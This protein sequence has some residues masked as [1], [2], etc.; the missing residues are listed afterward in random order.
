LAYDEHPNLFVVGDERQAIYRFQ[1]ADSTHFAEFTKQYPRTVTIELTDSFRSLQAILDLSQ[2]LADRQG[3]YQPLKAHREGVAD[4]KL[5]AA[6]DPLAERDQ[7]AGLVEEAIKKG[8]A[9]EEIAVIANK[10]ATADVF[11]E[12]L[13]ARGIPVLRAGDV[14]LSSR[15]VLRALL[16]FMRAVANPLDTASLRESLLAPWW[17]IPL[18]E[19]AEL[20]ARTRD[21][22]LLNTLAET[23]EEIV[24]NIRELQEA[25]LA[26]APLELF[27]LLLSKSGARAFMLSSAD[28]VDDLA[29]LRRLYAHLE[30][31]V[32]RDP[33]RSFSD[34]IE[35]LTKAQEHGLESVKSSVTQR[36]GFVTVITAHKAKGMEFEK[37]FVVGLTAREWEKG[38]RSPVIPSPVDSSKSLDDVIRLFF[39]AM[40]RAKNELVLSYAKETV[41]GKETPPSTLMPEDI[42]CIESSSNPLPEMHT[43]VKAP[44]LVRELTLRFLEHDGLSPSALNEYLESPASFFA[45]RVLRLKEPETPALVIGI[46]V[47]AGIATYLKEKDEDA[48]RADLEKNLKRSLLTRNAAYENIRTHARECL[49]AYIEANPTPPDTAAI[50]KAYSTHRTI[51]G[52]KVLLQGKIDAVFNEPSGECIVDFKTTSTIKA[53]DENYPRQLAFYDLLLKENGHDPKTARIVQVST[54]DVTDHAVALNEETRA[55]LLETLDAVCGELIRGEW[56]EGAPSDY[57]DL[58]Q[59]FT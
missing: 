26:K 25:V 24:T 22:E 39:V 57:D 30:E 43:T 47:H 10:N 1:G 11:A 36:P 58:L 35:Q 2:G 32:A 16:A 9:P 40:T 27:S 48:A 28:H 45:K 13:A 42:E 44:E 41:D 49:A 50:E 21:S 56:R 59:L 19:R 53:T 7:V 54:T 5:L 51:E 55:E 23:H 34:V 14:H 33:D 37:V 29:L 20:L 52:V 31:I 4:M 38:G 15:P 12:V 8:T 46:A 17:N 3:T 6:P 18:K